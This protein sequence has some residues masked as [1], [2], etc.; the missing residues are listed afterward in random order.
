MVE[1]PQPKV[2]AVKL[3]RWESVAPGAIGLKNLG[4][5]C[6]INVALQCILHTPDLLPAVLPR[7][8]LEELDA[9]LAARKQRQ[10]ESTVSTTKVGLHLPLRLIL[11]ILKNWL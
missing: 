9:I 2:S 4:N 11:P 8:E 5:T 6:F 7:E 1:P 3:T 10:Q